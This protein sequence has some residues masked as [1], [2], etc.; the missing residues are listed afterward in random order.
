MGRWLRYTLTGQIVNFCAPNDLGSVSG[1]R[2]DG[3]IYTFSALVDYHVRWVIETS[4][5]AM[6][7]FGSLTIYWYGA[8]YVASILV[9]WLYVRR[10][11]HL[12]STF[13]NTKDIDDLAIYITISIIV[14]GRLGH[15]AL[16]NPALFSEPLKL[17]NTSSGGL[18]FHGGL[19]TSIISLFVFSRAKNVNVAAVFDLKQQS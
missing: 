18:A 16:Y 15:A 8:C 1:G 11:S 7:R 4:P 2:E 13:N 5:K 9:G 6:I 3:L 12:T 17:A 14:G 10:L 19:A